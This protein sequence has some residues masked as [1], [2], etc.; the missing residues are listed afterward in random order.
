MRAG[1]ELYRSFDRDAQDNRDGLERGG[2]LTV[3]VLAV[4]G[5]TSISGGLMEE[6]MREVADDVTGVRI[7][8]TAHWVVE[9]NPQALVE[10]ILEFTGKSTTGG[11]RVVV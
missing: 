2:R 1:F 8:G 3:P 9:E 5:A 10:A 11:S 6:M 7:P 4:G